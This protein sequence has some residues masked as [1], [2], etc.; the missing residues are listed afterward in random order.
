MGLSLGLRDLAVGEEDLDHGRPLAPE[1]VGTGERA[2]S[3][4]DDKAV[5]A[6]LD[7]MQRSKLTTLGRA[8]CVKRE[9]RQLDGPFRDSMASLTHRPQSAP[10]Q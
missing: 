7:Q 1:E 3:T 4:T 9:R 8:D 2:V 6:L 5:D 10:F